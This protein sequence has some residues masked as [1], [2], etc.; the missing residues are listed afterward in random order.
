MPQNNAIAQQE[1]SKVYDR[2]NSVE[3]KVDETNGYLR[4][5]VESNVNLI[6]LLKRRD[7]TTNRIITALVFLLLFA[8][9]VIAYGAIGERGL[10]TV[11]DTLPSVPM[12]TDVLPAHN[13]FDKWGQSTA[14]KPHK[15]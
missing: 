3:S 4:G 2:I 15:K 11:R 6:D 5:V 9:G 12:Q 1:L 14:Q 10:K 13:D 8:I 7:T